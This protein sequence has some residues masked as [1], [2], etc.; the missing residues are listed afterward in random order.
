M[1]WEGSS[2]H[3]EIGNKFVV[4]SIHF[5]PVLSRLLSTEMW[6]S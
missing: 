6:N 2:Q 1:G 3:L 5:K 4:F